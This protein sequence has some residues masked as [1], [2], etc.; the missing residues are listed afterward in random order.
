MLNCSTEHFRESA[1]WGLE[2]KMIFDE[3]ELKEAKEHINNGLDKTLLSLKMRLQDYKELALA[4]EKALHCL[5]KDGCSIYERAVA[6][7]LREKL[8]KLGYR[9][10]LVGVDLWGE[11]S[12]HGNY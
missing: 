4:V 3:G 10:R 8:D 2:D 9:K 12:F 7:E 6:H 11:E 5:G 1:E